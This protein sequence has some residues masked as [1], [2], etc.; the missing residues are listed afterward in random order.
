M[1][2]LLLCV[3]MIMLLSACGHAP[4]GVGPAE[5]LALTIR[6]EYAA[7]STWTAQAEITADYGQRV[8]EYTVAAEFDG[9]QTRL[10]LTAPD[11]VT[12]LTAVLTE[13]SGALEFDGLW[14]ETG[15]LDPEG[16]PPPPPCPPWW[17]R[18]APA[19]S[20]P[21]AW[22][23]TVCCGWTAATRNRTPA[24]GRRPPCGSSR[25]AI[26]SCGER[27]AGRAF[28]PSGVTFP[29]FLR[30]DFA[31]DIIPAPHAR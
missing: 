27:S 5:E 28:G 8:Y 14:V 26:S 17:R 16:S 12:G 3:P 19:I 4:G 9:E 11:T 25:T 22:R 24:P 6:G 7:L 2:K 31:E 10:T 18:P 30:H 1:R 21:A 15:P 23:R 29:T 13:D 20:P